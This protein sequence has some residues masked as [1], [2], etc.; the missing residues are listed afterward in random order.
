MGRLISVALLTVLVT[1]GVAHTAKGPLVRRSIAELQ[2]AKSRLDGTSFDR[3]TRREILG[4]GGGIVEAVGPDLM[5]SVGA[6]ILGARV[7]LGVK[8][9]RDNYG[10]CRL[11]LTYGLRF[12]AKQLG[13]KLGLGLEAVDADNP[14]CSTGELLHGNTQD[15]R[16]RGNTLLLGNE[17]SLATMI[18]PEGKTVG[19]L[20]SAHAT[21]GLSRDSKAFEVA[22]LIGRL[23]LSPSWR[24]RELRRLDRW[25]AAYATFSRALADAEGSPSSSQRIER[26]NLAWERLAALDN[27]ATGALGAR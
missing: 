24:G 17:L 27:A 16:L 21:V 22:G 8:R 18:R 1:A 14:Y 25:L 5:A 10:R 11:E 26:A 15:G 6:Y 3:T 7:N 9:V 4:N 12:A 2:A 19:T 23:P 13:A 20:Q